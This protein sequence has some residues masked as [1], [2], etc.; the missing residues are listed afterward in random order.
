MS[1]IV[2]L[3]ID[4]AS[5]VTISSPTNGQVLA[6]NST[7]GKWENSSSGG[8]GAPIDATYIVASSNKTLS[9]EAVL[10]GGDGV[11]VTVASGTATVAMAVDTLDGATTLQLTDEIPI[12]DGTSHKKTTVQDIVDLATAEPAT[13]TI[14]TTTEGKAAVAG[15]NE[16]QSI[17][18]HVNDATGSLVLSFDGQST[19][20]NNVATGT[21]AS[22]LDTALESLSTIGSGNISISGAA[23]SLTNGVI[24]FVGTKA[25]ASQNLIAIGNASSMSSEQINVVCSEVTPGET[26]Q[27][28]LSDGLIDAWKFGTSVGLSTTTNSEI[29][30]LTLTASGGMQFS[31]G[32]YG[33]GAGFRSNATRLC[34]SATSSLLAPAGARSLSCWMYPA[35]P[36]DSMSV[37]IEHTSGH[38]FEIYLENENGTLVA[39]AKIIN[40]DGTVIANQPSLMGVGVWNHLCAVWD[41]DGLALYVNNE[42]SPGVLSHGGSFSGDAALTVSLVNCGSNEAIVDEVYYWGKAIS[43]QELQSL[44]EQAFYPFSTGTSEVQELATNG[45]PTQGN[46]RLTHSGSTVSVAYNASAATIQT[47]LRTISGL[48]GVTCS[49]GPLHQAAVSVTFPAE[50]GDVDPIGINYSGLLVSIARSQAG[51]AG[52]DGVNEVQQIEITGASSGTFTLT[53]DGNTTDPI[54]WDASADDIETAL[55]DAGVDSVSVTG[56]NPFDVEFTG[57]LAETDVEEMSADDGGLNGNTSA[58]AKRRFELADWVNTSGDEYSA[59]FADHGKGM[60]AIIQVQELVSGR[61][62]VATP[63]F[64]TYQDDESGDVVAL[65]N[66]ADSRRVI[67]I[68][69]K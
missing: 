62:K 41:G 22:G 55:I 42:G 11:S 65:V 56:S 53:H 34:T 38:L 61:W 45:T 58:T 1:G 43:R 35:F 16:K 5:N 32:V 26:G 30:N 19:T 67:R 40:T 57:S 9:A 31:E 3:P 63:E 27:S 13:V 59:T 17:T 46:V 68:L 60:S 49:G 15:A 39:R 2:S 18:W 24:E 12:H 47:A 64:D 20:I 28:S 36:D 14:T 23:S 7:T 10:T 66:G 37:K 6:Y 25:N 44:D 4:A 51:S 48:S 69:V 52:T 54:D 33:T 29:N 21:D 50:L 8:S